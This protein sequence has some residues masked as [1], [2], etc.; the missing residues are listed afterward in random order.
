MGNKNRIMKIN[1]GSHV[2][3]NISN[4]DKKSFFGG[5]ILDHAC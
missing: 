5:V 4:P 1:L 3:H 2:A